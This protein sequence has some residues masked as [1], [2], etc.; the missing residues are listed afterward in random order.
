MALTL[1][2]CVEQPNCKTVKVTEVTGVY[3]LAN[4][5]GWGTPNPTIADALTAEISIEKRKEDG[6]YENAVVID[7]FP[8]LPNITETPFSITG[9]DYNGVAN[10]TFADGIYK[11]TYEVTGDDGSPFTADVEKIVA[12][13]CN[14]E[15]CYQKLAD[16]AAKESCGEDVKKRFEE[17]SIL[18]RSLKA[19]KECGNVFSIQNQIDYL[20][21]LCAKCGCG[22]N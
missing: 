10:S 15:C 11:L 18:M 6:A 9:G 3:A 20:T 19:A 13:T 16:K 21:K 5:G 4:T 2:I 14:I 7:A 8:T 12:L 1:K 17:M 22:C